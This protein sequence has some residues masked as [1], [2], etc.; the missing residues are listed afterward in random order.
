MDMSVTGARQDSG[1]YTL[2]S[3]IFRPHSL[4]SFR[5]ACFKYEEGENRKTIYSSSCQCCKYFLNY[6]LTVV[7]KKINH[8]IFKALIFWEKVKV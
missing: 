4:P 5:S 1:L 2:H 7:G 6:I 3:F 8:F